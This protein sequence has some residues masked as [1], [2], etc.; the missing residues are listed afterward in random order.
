M[1]YTNDFMLNLV[2]I[3]NLQF[4]HLYAACVMFQPME[5]RDLH[6]KKTG[7]ELLI[8]VQRKVKK[9]SDLLMFGPNPGRFRPASFIMIS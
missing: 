1:M 4:E 5:I 7:C 6:K 3:K 2:W 9:L 8:D